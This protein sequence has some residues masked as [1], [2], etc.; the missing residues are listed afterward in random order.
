MIEY[1]IYDHNGVL[2]KAGEIDRAFIGTLNIP[3][4]GSLHIKYVEGWLNF[5]TT[6]D[7]AV[8]YTRTPN[9]P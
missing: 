1:R 5:R 3:M 8:S 4:R 2:F 6:E 7:L 9:K